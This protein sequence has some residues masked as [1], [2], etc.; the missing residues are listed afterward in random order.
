MAVGVTVV[1]ALGMLLALPAFACSP[2]ANIQVEPARDEAGA[3]VQVTGNLFDPEGGTIKLWW[4]GGSGELLATLEAPA[5]GTFAQQV[6]IPSSAEA[7]PHSITAT[8]KAS[9][10]NWYTAPAAFEVTEP[11]ATGDDGAQE[12]APAQDEPAA[13]EQPAE[14]PAAEEQPAGEPVAEEQPAPAEEPVAEDRLEP[15]GQPVEEPAPQQAAV[16]APP[17]SA[18]GAT[19][20]RQNG[21][22]VDEPAVPSG[23]ARA[24]ALTEPAPVGASHP[25]V[26]AEQA[27]HQDRV[28][29][30]EPRPVDLPG[31]SA[32]VLVPIALVATGLFVAGVGTV[33][34]E[35]RERRSRAQA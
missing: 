32:W 23:I 25:A 5:D 2:N 12:P 34:H 33:V 11:A 16:A 10:G 4:D 3:T 7:G 13:E 31:P 6:T 18:D 29:A 17:G 30:A 21:V 15:V 20:D 28:M 8:Q 35:V 1:V 9:D 19:T 22:A 27:D 14:E 24:E 26:S